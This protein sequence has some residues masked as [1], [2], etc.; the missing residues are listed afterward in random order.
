MR[1]GRLQWT[2]ENV[3]HI[4]RHAVTPQE[5]EQVFRL[6]PKV[7]RARDGRYLLL[8][9]TAAGRYLLVV[10]VY[11]GRGTARVITARDMDEKERKHYGKRKRE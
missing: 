5:A 2:D 9:Q 11:L 6:R 8:G 1:V 10:F 7:R 4:S 3:E